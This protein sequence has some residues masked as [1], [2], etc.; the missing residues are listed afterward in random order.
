M[1]VF[2]Y[3]VPTF[4]ITHLIMWDKKNE[5]YMGYVGFI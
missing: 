4:F 3:L 2:I 1:G 5:T